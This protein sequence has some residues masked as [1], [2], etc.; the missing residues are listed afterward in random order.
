M[1]FPDLMILFILC[2]ALA[3][4]PLQ[5]DYLSKAKAGLIPGANRHYALFMHSSIHAGLVFLISH[6]YIIT[7]GELLIHYVTDE[8][9]V[10]HKISYALDQAIH[11]TCKVIW[12]ALLVIS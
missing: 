7:A 2:H 6:S 10:K 4:Y 12:A 5:G 9:K 1:S 11:L 8:L 3:D